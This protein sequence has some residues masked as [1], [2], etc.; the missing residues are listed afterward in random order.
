VKRRAAAAL[1]FALELGFRL[2][3][4]PAARAQAADPAPVPP[5]QG[6]AQAQ[7]ERSPTQL[8]PEFWTRGKIVSAGALASTYAALTVWAYF[9]WYHNHLQNRYFKVNGDGLFG[10]DTY[11]G[12]SDKLGHFWSNHTISRGTAEMLIAGGWKPLPASAIASGLCAAFFAFVEVKNGYYYEFSTGD[13]VADLGGAALGMLLINRPELDA[14]IDFRVDY[15]PTPEYRSG[16]EDGD[17]NFAED[18]SGQTYFLA[19][20]LAG[21]PGL[22]DSKWMRWARYL[23]LGIGFQSLNYKPEPMD[24]AAI[25]SQH[26]FLGAAINLQPLLEDLY[27]ERYERGR[28]HVT[29]QVGHFL[30]E[31]VSPPYTTLRVAGV[32]RSQ[33]GT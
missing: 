13:L 26:L 27:G 1:A 30:L 9:A 3:A 28:S 24:P 22:T 16:V 8:G 31:F 33:N 17:V 2:G 15:W 5:S 29:H 4:A 6:Q 19:A 11:A 32:S 10:V 12:G 20:H 25:P 14:L 18:Y 21:V 7:P 23:D